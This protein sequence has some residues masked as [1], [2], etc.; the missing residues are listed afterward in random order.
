M[1]LWVVCL[2]IG[3][4]VSNKSAH[5]TYK[6]PL[7]TSHTLYLSN[8]QSALSFNPNTYLKPIA[9]LPY[10]RGTSSQVQ[11]SNKASSSHCIACFY[12]MTFKA[13]LNDFG[14][15]RISVP[16]T[17]TIPT[18]DLVSIEWVLGVLD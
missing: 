12:S 7:A 6:N 1:T 15:S 18:L 4:K 11:L 9:T 8:V 14:S 5:S 13:S 2:I 3:G 10:D 16:W 17:L